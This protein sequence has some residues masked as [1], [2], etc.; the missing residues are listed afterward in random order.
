M[1]N[2]RQHG[3]VRQNENGGWYH[4]GDE[5]PHF[6]KVEV[7][8]DFFERWAET[9]PTKPSY[10]EIGSRTK[11]S[12]M[13]V[14]K[15]LEEFE[16]EGRI[17]DPEERKRQKKKIDA[18]NTILTQ[19]EETFLLSLR[20]EDPARP[21]MSYVNELLNNFGKLVSVSYLNRWWLER[22]SYKASFR[23]AS[24]IPKD[25]FT[26][27]NWYRYYEYRL[28]VEYINDNLRFNFV[29]E[30][31]VVNHNGVE[32]RVRA[33]PLTGMVDA[34]PVSGNFRDSRSLVATISVNPN[35]TK[36]IFY[37]MTSDTIN[38]DFFMYYIQAMVKEGFLKPREVLVLDNAAVHC[39]AAARELQHYLWNVRV[40]GIQLEVLVLYLPTRAPE[41]NPIE[42]V[43]HILS[44]RLKSFH[45][46][47]LVSL[48]AGVE[49][50][51]HAVLNDI[52]R[53]LL[54]KCYEHCGY[55]CS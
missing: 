53:S 17:L 27:T 54:V 15:F 24:L 5:Y 21:T 46:R 26:A 14:K 11:V 38:A 20:A 12:H 47:N 6:K 39:G 18:T 28:T 55:K 22:F 32:Q 49:K 45:Y 1:S 29:D 40:N 50:K 2:K 35:K 41:L 9:F 19:Q 4:C 16:R 44:R 30:K 43:F 23:K 48:N 8:E 10:R 51:I 31:H 3:I 42:L 36:H 33:N 7:V 25:K 13:T 52:T 37:T 34:L